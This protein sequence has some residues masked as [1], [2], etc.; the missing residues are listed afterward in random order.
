MDFGVDRGEFLQRLH[1]SEP[2]HRA[3]PSPE[4]K[5]TVFVPVVSPTAHLATIEISQFAHRG[6]GRFEPVS[7]DGFGPALAFQRFLHESE[8]G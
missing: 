8:S 7:N 1:S 4:G 3:L 5:M 6:R 2:K